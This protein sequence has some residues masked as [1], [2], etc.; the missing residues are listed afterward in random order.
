M[1]ERKLTFG[2]RRALTMIGSTKTRILKE[3]ES[4]SAKALRKQDM[5]I[6]EAVD[7]KKDVSEV[8]MASGLDQETALHSIAWLLNT[9]FI[10]SDQT[11]FRI[12]QKETD[13][14]VLFTEVFRDPSH[15]IGFWQKVLASIA[16]SNSTLKK[17]A[18]GLEWDGLNPKLADPLPTPSQL[19]D[20]FL[21]LY[22]ALYDKAEE[23][24]GTEAVIAKRIL[25]DVR[26]K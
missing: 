24:L 7:D 1:D 17:L 6:L 9:G 26:S 4:L 15:D 18:P 23:F 8:I 25:L 3:K 16:D 11:L 21:E 13:R 2:A 12:L 14:L 20:Y 5:K 10:Y 22:V 19:K